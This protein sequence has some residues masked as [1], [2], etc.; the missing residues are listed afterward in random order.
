MQAKL[1]GAW[2]VL[3]SFAFAPAV[4]SE[5]PAIFVGG[6]FIRQHA[7]ED[8]HGHLLVPVRGV[9]EAFHADVTY[10]PPRFVVVR[11]NGSVVAGLIVG[12]ND[13]VVGNKP[14]MLPVAPMRRDG[15]VYVPLRLIAEI[16]G[17]TVAYSSHP[18]V[19]DIRAPFNDLAAVAPLADGQ[20]DVPDDPAVPLWAYV[21]I[22]V[23]VLGFLSELVRRVI[24]A[25]SLKKERKLP[26]SAYL[27][28]GAP[29]L[30]LPYSPDPGDHH[31]IGQV[32]K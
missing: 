10:T 5:A 26:P 30:Q 23:A 22:G 15:R 18:R 19:V 20:A 6:E 3:A 31:R 25:S 13:A 16:A 17:A 24:I 2:A 11:K 9:F 27:P 4:A 7:I 32:V 21:L 1:L 8:T 14:R 28:L 12:R 29:P